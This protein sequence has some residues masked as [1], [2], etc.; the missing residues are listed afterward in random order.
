M[1]YSNIT[2]RLFLLGLIELEVVHFTP[3]YSLIN[4]LQT[5]DEALRGREGG[6]CSP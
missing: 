2:R 5:T 3:K 1:H 4:S 6:I